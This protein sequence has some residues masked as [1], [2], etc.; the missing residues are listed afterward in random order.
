MDDKKYLK[1]LKEALTPDEERLKSDLEAS[2]RSGKITDM[3]R[4]RLA[5]L[6][7]KEWR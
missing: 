3:G 1:Y 2:E 4:S 5:Q 6:K 7:D